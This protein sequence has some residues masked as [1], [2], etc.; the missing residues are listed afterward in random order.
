MASIGERIRSGWNA[1]MGRDPTDQMNQ[2]IQAGAAYSYRPDQFRYRMTSAKSVVCKVYNRI[3]VDVASATIVHAKCDENGNYVETVKDGLNT[4]LTTSANVDQT[5]VDLMLDAVQ[6]MC[7][8]GVVALVPV[9]TSSDPTGDSES[10]DILS[11]RTG[12]I[13]QWYPYYVKVEVF[14]ERVGQHKQITLPKKSVA[15]IQNPFYSIMN[16]PSSTMQQLLRTIS[17]LDRANDQNANGKLDLIIQL[18]YT[19]RSEQRKR[20]AEQR[21]KDLENQLNSAKLGVGYIDGTEKVVQL[22]RS[23]ENNLWTQVKELTTQL[24]NELGLTQ[25]IL[26]GTA[27]EQASINYFNNT[28]APILTAFSLEMTRKFLSKTARSQGHAVVFFRDPFKYTPIDQFADIAQK[29]KTAEIMTSNELRSKIGLRPVEDTESHADDL[30]NPNTNTAND[31]SGDEEDIGESGAA[32]V[33]KVL[34]GNENG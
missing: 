24:Y 11:M 9:D 28:I 1:F 33:D 29:L 17:K 30:R 23:L 27:D 25:S 7:D 34:G 18:P 5:G 8:E 13:I 26:D 22:N 3:A 20:E 6:S 15:I 21:R 14:D 31:G 12:R 19:I 4:C 10:Y 32:I 16:E 2:V